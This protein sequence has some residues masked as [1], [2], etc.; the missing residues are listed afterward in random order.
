MLINASTNAPDS[1]DH[2]KF[3]NITNIQDASKNLL[4]IDGKKMYIV[5]DNGAVVVNNGQIKVASEGI[6]Y[7]I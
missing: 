3:R 2:P 1:I 5:D 7:E 6:W 4:E